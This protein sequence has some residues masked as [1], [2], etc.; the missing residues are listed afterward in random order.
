MNRRDLLKLGV[1]AGAALIPRGVRGQERFISKQGPWRKFEVVTR[2]EFTQPQMKLQAWVPVPSVSQDDWSKPL[3]SDWKTN[4]KVAKLAH[5]E[6]T[7]TDLAYFEWAESKEPPVAEVSSHVS[8]RD[9]L[10]DFTRPAKPTPLTD[11]ERRQ[12]T[13]LSASMRSGYWAH[14]N[15]LHATASGIIANAK[16]DLG[17]AKAIY[18]WI[19][20]KES[21]A[22]GDLAV[23]QDAA[24]PDLAERWD[25]GYLNSIFVAL[26]RVSG[27]PA[28][29]YY[30]IRVAPSLSGYESLSAI[31][32]NIT[33]K[34]HRRAEVWL[35]DYGWVPVDPGDVRTVIR[36][37][38][39]GTLTLEAPKVVAARVTLFGAW[40][41]NWVAYNMAEDYTLPNSDGVKVPYIAR[42]MT[43]NASGW[44]DERKRDA[45]TYKIMAKELP[46]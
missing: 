4:A 7:G 39:P 34:E 13:T 44:L 40:E 25:C 11:A 30:G 24:P 15:R 10:T 28:R 14:D 27:L 18:E 43:R 26:A 32:E 31:S 6:A 35:E 36:D 12:F 41:G 1:L 22:A 46:A 33:V 5:D 23:F 45:F 37:E 8:T 20:E 16:T 17:K 9:R 3:G 29:E 2:I 38:P 21:C 42:P 19:V